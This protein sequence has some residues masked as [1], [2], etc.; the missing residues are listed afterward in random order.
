MIQIKNLDFKYE[1]EL[2]LKNINLEL[3]DGCYTAIIG[4]NGSGKTTLAKHLNA[5]LMP[6][7]GSVTIDEIDTKKDQISVRKKV[8]FV[9]QNPE[10]QLVYSIVEED[11]AFGLENLGMRT[12]EMKTKVNSTIKGLDIEYL[13]K[14]NVN[15]LS[16]GQKQLTALAG[17]LAMSPK[18]IVFD[19]PTTLLDNKNKKNIMD[20]VNTLN[21]ENKIGIILVTNLLNDIKYAKN[22]IV[23]CNGRIIFNDKKS[24]LNNKILKKAGLD[25]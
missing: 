8:G 23:I 24:K 2:I 7:K 5:L 12:E 25:A 17:I 11:I 4:A 22:V 13:A 19:E 1:D 21:K 20:V 15:I 10:D 18:Y 3:K 6:T 14:K 9:F 16:A